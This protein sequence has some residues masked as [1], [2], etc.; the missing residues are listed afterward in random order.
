MNSNRKL[1]C[2]RYHGPRQLTSVVLEMKH[3]TTYLMNCWLVKY[4]STAAVVPVALS[5]SALRTFCI[6]HRTEQFCTR[7]PRHFMYRHIIYGFVFLSVQS[8][9]YPAAW[10]ARSARGP[11]KIFPRRVACCCTPNSYARTLVHSC[12]YSPWRCCR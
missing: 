2:L 4:S 12:Q 6:A 1:G 9:R 3:S 10:S 5:C 7:E 11:R 8:A